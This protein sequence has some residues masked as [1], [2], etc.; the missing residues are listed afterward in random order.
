MQKG[1]QD[2]LAKPD[3]TI[4]EHAEDL[5]MQAEILWDLGYVKDDHIY[6]L[7]KEACLHHDDGKANSAFDLRVRGMNRVFD[8]E[9]EVVHNILSIYY[10]NPDNYPEKD[11]LTIACAILYHHNYC[12]EADVINEKADLIEE[13]LIDEYAHKLK[14]KHKRQLLGNCILNPETIMVK[15][16][17]HR[18]DYSASGNYTVEYP[19]NFLIT[20]L[21]EMMKRWQKK[22]PC[23]QWNEVQKFCMQNRDNDVIVVASTGMG[24]TE[25]GLQWI[26]DNKGFFVLPIRTAI[27]AIYDRVKDDVL[28]GEKLNERL[29]LLHSEALEYYGSHTEEMDI[30]EYHDR[31]KK[32]SLP[33]NISTMDQL[34]DFVF[35]YKGYEMKLVTLAYSKLVIDEIQMYGPDLLAYLVCGIRKIHELGGKIAIVTA[36]LPPFIRDIL[37]N[38]AAIPFQ[39]SRFISDKVR[40]SVKV[41]ECSMPVNDILECYNKNIEVG[42]SN[43]ILVV[44]N[45]IRKAQVIYNQLREAGEDINLHIF[46][47]RFTKADRKSLEREIWEFGITYKDGT[48]CLDKQNG[49]WISTSLVEV[50]LDID[51]DYLFS[52]LSELNALFQR[53]GRCNRKGVKEIIDYNCFVYCD[54]SDV[55]RGRKGFVDE[56]LY[57]CSREALTQ[58]DGPLSESEKMS[59]I[60]K[61]FT[62]ERV[63]KSDF[64]KE[65]KKIFTE[66]CSL[67]VG[68]YGE[69]EEVQL[70]TISTQ[71]VVPKP[72][73]EENQEWISG[74]ENRLQELEKEI[75][76]SLVEKNG[77]EVFAQL[78]NERMDIREK[79]KSFIVSIPKYEY[80]NYVKKAWI[81]YG[82][83]K[84]SRYEIV[85]VIDCIYDEKG[86]SPLNYNDKSVQNEIMM[87]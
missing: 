37:V 63:G 31:G 45:T 14:F 5:L 4:K 38:D 11:Y 71:D 29:A 24:K 68:E 2:Y 44:C 28:N 27:N 47:S 49:I 32:L 78:Y 52:E 50:S 43:K 7:L 26:G 74:L 58:V 48:K 46:H 66:F 6:F 57:Q 83:I 30:L 23:S 65:Y 12:N 36:T 40:H 73:Y 72:V 59:L 54:G 55:R 41:K 3:K 60:D 86:Y 79:L 19:N 70:R 22:D 69:K 15:G 61:Y 85:P 20:A 56:V 67:K 35:K 39:E 8:E 34:F 84:I 76:R 87:L 33:L 75:K 13:L 18:C 64:M 42:R 9:K 21:D 1:I 82:K 77:K 80:K 17:L 10:L 51:F 81:S 53:L 16:L 62:T 25:A